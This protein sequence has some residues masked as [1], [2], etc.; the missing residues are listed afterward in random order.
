MTDCLEHLEPRLV[1]KHFAALSAIPRPSKQEGRVRQYV[2]DQAAQWRCSTSLDGVG[3]LLVRKPGSPG[4]EGEPILVLQGH[5]DMVGEKNEGVDHDFAQDPLQ[6]WRDGDWLRARGTTLGADNGIGCAA[7]LAA[8][9]DTSLSHPPLECLFTIDEETGLTGANQLQPGW[10]QGRRLLN[11]DTEEEG[12]L[13]IGCAG[14]LDSD[15]TLRVTRIP[16]NAGWVPQRLKVAGLQGGHSGLDIHRQRGNAVKILARILE[17]LRAE[18][19]VQIGSLDGGDKRNAIPR[20]ARALLYLDPGQLAALRAR[21]EQRQQH[22]RADL[23]VADPGVLLTLD[24]WEPAPDEVLDPADATRLLDYLLACPHG[25]L[26]MTPG[27]PDLVQTSTNLASIASQ[28]HQVRVGLSH[29]SSRAADKQALG[30]RMRA[31]AEQG[32]FRVVQGDGYPGWEPNPD[33]PLLA[34][35]RRIHR[36]VLGRDPA[37]MAVH[38]GLECGLIGEKYPEMDMVSL[39]PTIQGAHSPD[40]RLDIPAT[41]QFWEYLKALLARL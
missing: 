36:E 12:I 27:F 26:A 32:G 13:Y 2:M 38:A 40:E 21:L 23:G 25:V 35:C 24:S 28:G 15:L 14:G 30:D 39:G 17:E 5:L 4:R 41:A 31:Q 9:E 6:L 37:V 3:N 16:A 11:L 22:L 34:A 1:W 8:L 33:S 29:R 18:F 7:A 10:L 19:G 20:E